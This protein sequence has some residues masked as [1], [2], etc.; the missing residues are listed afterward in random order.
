MMMPFLSDFSSNCLRK[1]ADFDYRKF[2][3]SDIS[4]SGIGLW[5]EVWVVGSRGIN[6]VT[7]DTIF[8]C[9]RSERFKSFNSV[10][11]LEVSQSR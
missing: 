1:L 3:A 9:L 8:N 4:V 10:R 11:F 2:L 6:R 7:T 5:E